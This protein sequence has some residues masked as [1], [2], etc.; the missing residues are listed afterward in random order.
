M[1]TVT[2]DND[3]TPSPVPWGWR[4]GAVAGRRLTLN[5]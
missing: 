4:D 5:G 1:Q 2:L 3:R